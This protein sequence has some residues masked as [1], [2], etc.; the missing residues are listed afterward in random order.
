MMLDAMVTLSLV[1]TE[2]ADWENLVWIFPLNMLGYL[3]LKI[4]N[5]GLRPVYSLTDS[6][7]VVF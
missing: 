4:N 7:Y 5:A 2:L 3:T 6:V 1:Q